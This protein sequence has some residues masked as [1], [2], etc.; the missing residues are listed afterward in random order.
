MLNS[1]RVPGRRIL[2]FVPVLTYCLTAGLAWAQETEKQID[3]WIGTGRTS[4]SRGIYHCTLNTRTG[5]LSQPVLAAEAEGPGFLA[6]HPN[7]RRLYAVCGIDGKASVAEFR[8]H[9]DGAPQLEL[10]RSLEIGDGGGTHLCLDRTSRVLLT[11]QYGGGSVAVFRLDEDGGL[12]ERTQL[13]RHHG[14][15][16]VVAGRQDAPHAHWVGVSPD[17]RYAFVPDLG[18]DQVVIY[19]LDASG[20]TIHPH[21]AAVGPPGSG[22]RHMKFHPDGK[23]LY[24]LN[25]LDV[26][27]STFAF[28]SDA[29]TAISRE[30]V[31]ALSSEDK[32][33]EQTVSA[34]EI[35][36]HPSGRFVYS[37]NRGHD[38]ISV[39]HVDPQS[40]H[41]QLVEQENVRGATPR[42]FNLSPDGRWLVAAGQD[43]HTLAVF[44]V[45][46]QS[47]ELTYN[48]SVVSAPSPICVLFGPE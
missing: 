4:V 21:G 6:M 5:K 7:R 44:A 14:G 18:M 30:T 34:S 8:I 19:R 3:V 12:V 47:G 38:T 23:R 28:D 22:P 36:I 26:S 43:S 31:P 25:E 9:A 37:A 39:F 2:L 13:V 29:G 32:A 17:N 1:F 11:A 35:R 46:Q 41:L 24:V 45:D 42:N 20:A 27:V 33:K 15:S 40:G 48:R 16:G 10:I